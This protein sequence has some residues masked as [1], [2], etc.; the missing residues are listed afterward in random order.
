MKIIR[1]IC[2]SLV[3][4]TSCTIYQTIPTTESFNSEINLSID[5]VI[6]NNSIAAGNFSY[7]ARDGYNFAQLKIAFT[8]KTSEKQELDFEKIFLID[9]N[10]KMK[11]NLEFCF[12]LGPVTLGARKKI[13]IAPNETLRRILVFVFPENVKPEYILANDNLIKITYP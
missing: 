13:T 5:R 7:Y 12:L 8:N 6:L 4:L 2:I 9:L 1:L 10:S 11:Y 3:L